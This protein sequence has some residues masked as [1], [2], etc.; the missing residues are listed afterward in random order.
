[1]TMP[2]V[3]WVDGKLLRLGT[4]SVTSVGAGAGAGAGAGGRCGIC[5]GL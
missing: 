5:I 3:V 4:C 1:M 2:A